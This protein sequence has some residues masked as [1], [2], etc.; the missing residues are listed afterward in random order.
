MDFRWT[1]TG[2]ISQLQQVMDQLP[3]LAQQSFNKLG[4]A[5]AQGGNVLENYVGSFTSALSQSTAAAS[6]SAA[7]IQAM[8]LIA[9]EVAKLLPGLGRIEI[10]GPAQARSL[11]RLKD[12]SHA[13]ADE[14]QKLIAT[15]NTLKRE[16]LSL[17]KEG[18]EVPE[19]LQKK[20]EQFASMA[21]KP[22]KGFKEVKELQQA[23]RSLWGSA[24]RS[25][26]ALSDFRKTLYSVG[27]A[28]KKNTSILDAMNERLE[29]TKHSL[30][31]DARG[32]IDAVQGA[33]QTTEV[34]TT[35]FEKFKN[36][37]STL[38]KL[39]LGTGERFTQF[40]RIMSKWLIRFGVI[41]T[42]R[43]IFRDIY[44]ITQQIV[45]SAT[46]A[47]RALDLESTFNILALT[48]K[49]AAVTV[50][51]LQRATGGLADRSVIAEK[52]MLGL[53]AGLPVS[54]FKELFAIG[55]KL[56]LMTG[57][58]QA[59]AVERLTDALSKLE[60]RRL[61]ELG[62]IVKVT[63]ATRAAMLMYGKEYPEAVTE[64]EKQQAFFNLVMEQ[65]R[66]IIAQLSAGMFDQ[67][68]ELASLSARWKDLRLEW[69]ARLIPVAEWLT[70]AASGLVDAF[71]P[72]RAISLPDMLASTVTQVERLGNIREAVNMLDKLKQ[73]LSGVGDASE[74]TAEKASDLEL[75]FRTFRGLLPELSGLTGDFNEQ[76]SQAA[77]I[78]SDL[79]PMMQSIVS[80]QLLDLMSR[81]SERV[82]DI[83]DSLW[84]VTNLMSSEFWSDF[85]RDFAKIVDTVAEVQKAMDGLAGSETDQAEAIKRMSSEWGE[86]TG[87]Q[88][89]FHSAL[90]SLVYLV[91]M[92][93]D[94]ELRTKL[95]QS[96]IKPLQ[97]F[98]RQLVDFSK[99]VGEI[100]VLDTS[101]FIQTP[102]IAHKQLSVLL[103]SLEVNLARLNP[104]TMEVSN[105]IASMATEVAESRAEG[106]LLLVML[107]QMSDQ[108]AKLSGVTEADKRVFDE[109]TKAIETGNGAWLES[110]ENIERVDKAIMSA[111]KS[112]I[113]L[114]PVFSAMFPKLG[115][116]LTK[117]GALPSEVNAT[118]KDL[119][120]DL[121]GINERF[122][123]MISRH[124][125]Q[126]SLIVDQS[127]FHKQ[128]ASM[129]QQHIDALE[130]FINEN[131][132]LGSLER[133]INNKLIELAVSRDKALVSAY[134]SMLKSIT[135]GSKDS[136]ESIEMTQRKLG[137][138]L[139]TAREDL[140]DHP[141][142]LAKV[143]EDIKIELE[144]LSEDMNK[145]FNK[146]AED[147]EKE[148]KRRSEEIERELSAR[149]KA[150]LKQLENDYQ[151][152]LDKHAEQIKKTRELIT[153]TEK[154]ATKS[155]L[156]EVRRRAN[157]A[158]LIERQAAAVR[159]AIAKR[160]REIERDAIREIEDEI[161]QLTKESAAD[162][163]REKIEEVDD[164]TAQER[165][166]YKL[167]LKIAEELSKDISQVNSERMINS[168]KIRLEELEDEQLRSQLMVQLRK[169]ALELI[170]AQNEKA[171]DKMEQTASEAYLK[172]IS[173][174]ESARDER[175]KDIRESIL[176]EKDKAEQIDKINRSADEAKIE[177][178]KKYVAEAQE[179]IDRLITSMLTGSAMTQ[180]SLDVEIRKYESLIESIKN[181][182]N[183]VDE[184]TE[185]ERKLAILRTINEK[186]RPALVAKEDN[187]ATIELANS[188]ESLN[189]SYRDSV[190]SIN[191]YYSVVSDLI[192]QNEDIA[193]SG[194]SLTKIEVEHKKALIEVTKQ[195]FEKR[196]EISRLVNTLEEYGEV[197]D[198]VNSLLSAIGG[199]L[200]ELRYDSAESVSNWL[201][202]AEQILNI[203][204]NVAKIVQS[205]DL[206]NSALATS[207]STGMS[208][209]ETLALAGSSLGGEIGIIIAGIA[210][211]AQAG[212][213]A[214]D[215]L[216]KKRRETEKA[217][218]ERIAALR[219]Q[220]ESVVGGI[221]SSL[222]DQIV[223][224]WET[225]VSKIDFSLLIKRMIAEQVAARMAE[226]LTKPL[227]ESLQQPL[228]SLL[229]A[230]S[231]AEIESV[232]RRLMSIAQTQIPSIESKAEVATQALQ[233]VFGGQ[234]QPATETAYSKAIAANT[235][236]MVQALT[237]IDRK[238]S[239][240][241]TEYSQ[242]AT[243]RGVELRVIK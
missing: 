81:M 35:R 36:I 45:D 214:Y 150:F 55:S 147:A 52:A 207:E 118:V 186:L 34:A 208:L 164:I 196:K 180:S 59:D 87:L 12:A 153:A 84:F 21:A 103:R 124:E 215:L 217:E 170:V 218:L 197:A 135:A 165:L 32:F 203:S 195:Y 18:T 155:Q 154:A 33:S 227:I 61:D 95:E 206:L 237:S 37:L 151:S 109:L 90:R 222:A 228:Q 134:Q 177:S 120:T 74:L 6:G 15:V 79:A 68:K 122:E 22:V 210:A 82:D 189:N 10:V 69:S 137:E 104:K 199:S 117:I 100:A 64:S 168:M 9:S 241:G 73:E 138:V 140:A 111:T 212:I 89:K 14:Q 178:T 175:I 146:A 131:E 86:L 96:L 91:K 183:T 77:K 97:E 5:V 152:Y 41:A 174:I 110:A 133:E 57:R 26:K 185:A 238:I 205:V 193:E 157:E 60:R 54:Q 161:D 129:Y 75:M 201:E 176:E 240:P 171:I 108:L 211:I 63:D 242:V 204:E 143:I 28:T 132:D 239:N 44:N 29:M 80:K 221:S 107:R 71:T 65:G 202:L 112:N 106:K 1:W 144:K 53:A 216:T 162:R 159:V 121:K 224:G 19:K 30:R 173:R 229:S 141:R 17:E 105:S 11:Y 179:Q 190:E 184:L 115:D 163:I 93:P 101:K 56:A 128:L 235:M 94:K 231:Q 158:G 4:Q 31:V 49:N 7:A 194:L 223:E 25:G 123:E 27:F 136:I 78:L 126:S 181:T 191:R 192:S 225:G 226:V 42:V 114:L 213:K 113:S 39:L 62:I 234:L 166:K 23:F 160:S 92:I 188:V 99:S 48:S 50:N 83:G 98:D 72:Q 16:L 139:Q 58:D 145:L 127:K 38:P 13:V 209:A 130:A 187:K 230:Q 47:A 233:P 119:E 51:E 200:S 182:G 46:H 232:A 85:S 169:K 76:L 8:G 66:N 88:I 70:R 125:L 220:V 172:E 219:S 40:D 24:A 243:K 198:S 43:Y 148:R 149:N 3:S 102:A 116:L 167:M 156:D 236:L 20:F 142:A 67:S 2:D